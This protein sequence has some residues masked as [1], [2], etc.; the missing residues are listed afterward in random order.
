M[1]Q[2]TNT[3]SKKKQNQSEVKYA[4]LTN[5]CFPVLLSKVEP[6]TT[7]FV[8]IAGKWLQS[9]QLKQ[10]RIYQQIHHSD[11]MWDSRTQN[12]CYPL[13][14]ASTSNHEDWS[15]ECKKN[16]LRMISESMDLDLKYI[17][18]TIIIDHHPIQFEQNGEKWDTHHKTIMKIYVYLHNQYRNRNHIHLYY[19]N[20][21]H[22]R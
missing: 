2:P 4:W 16:A 1:L 8:G 20:F 17:N 3:Q 15:C 5:S 11:R 9:N 7:L 19:I 6:S 14:K 10:K 13:K 18:D 22:F 21:Q 12:A